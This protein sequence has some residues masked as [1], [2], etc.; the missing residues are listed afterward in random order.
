MVLRPPIQNQPYDKVLL[1]FI[2]CFTFGIDI[3]NLILD[4]G[5]VR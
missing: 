2:F 1:K 5:T 3:T 4:H